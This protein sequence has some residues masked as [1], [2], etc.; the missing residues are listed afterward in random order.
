MHRAEVETWITNATA[1]KDNRYPAGSV[2]MWIADPGAVSATAP[3]YPLMHEGIADVFTGVPGGV[4][5]RGDA[6]L[7]PIVATTGSR[8]VSKAKANPTCAAWSSSAAR[9]TRCA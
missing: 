9:W 4:S 2:A 8:A 7:I 3:E 1:D 5:P 6:L